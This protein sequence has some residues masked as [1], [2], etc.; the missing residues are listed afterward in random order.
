MNEFRGSKNGGREVLAGLEWPE[1]GKIRRP[2]V[3]AA[4][5]FA[6]PIQAR[7]MEV[8]REISRRRSSGGGVPPYPARAQGWWPESAPTAKTRMA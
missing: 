5:A 3:A 6:G 1:N 8:G 2:K 7:P 4:A